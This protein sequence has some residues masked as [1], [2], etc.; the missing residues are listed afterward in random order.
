MWKNSFFCEIIGQKGSIHIESLCKWGPSK[1]IFRK[2]IMPSGKPLERIKIMKLADPTWSLE[3]KYFK[4]LIKIKEKNVLNKDLWIFET[5]M[6]LK[7][8]I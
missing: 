2:R 5:L 1:F 6:K 3:H 8:K 4:N 7:S